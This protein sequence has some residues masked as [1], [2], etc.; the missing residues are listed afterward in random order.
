MRLAIF[1][2][3]M[4]S[5]AGLATAGDLGNKPRLTKN[6]DHVGLNPGTPYN[7][8]GGEDM[9]TAVIIPALPFE[10]TGNTVGHADDYAVMCPYGSWAPDLW[11]SFTP[12]TDQIIS[13]DLCGSGY[14]TAVF[15]IDSEYNLIACND[16]YH[17]D[18][19]CGNYTSMIEE[20]SLLAANEY[21]II[22]DGYTNDA[23]DYL[24]NVQK[25]IQPPPCHLIC[26]GVD[27]NEPPPGPGYSDAWNGG[28]NSPESDNPFQIL[29]ADSNGE[30]TF[31]GIAGWTGEGRD[32]DWFTI[33]VGETGVVEWTVDSEMETSILLL[34]PN[35]C[36]S[37]GVISEKTA[38]ICNP[39]TMI[40]E[41]EPGAV[42]WLWAGSNSYE[43]PPGFAG[44]QYNYTCTFNGLMPGTVSV[45]R[46]SFDAIKSL[47]R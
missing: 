42:L 9:T 47:Y 24:L 21:F 33:I 7:R 17:F 46:V 26:A 31:C 27:E 25:I 36:N 20:A 30:L 4:I 44:W 3:L 13:V 22:V 37:V 43:P 34:G 18:D 23:G 15:I 2:I 14:D 1:F 10:D 40:I 29:E 11:Y 6:N 19:G 41:S 38:G 28:C 35:D 39:V 45:D 32:T 5:L 12:L 8:E 16:D